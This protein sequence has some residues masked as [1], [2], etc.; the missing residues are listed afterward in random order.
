MTV[1]DSVR[2]VEMRK[3]LIRAQVA[4]DL[5]AKLAELRK[6]YPSLSM[7]ACGSLARDRD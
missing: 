2:D 7:S 4:A 6:Q 1:R 5:R 3:R